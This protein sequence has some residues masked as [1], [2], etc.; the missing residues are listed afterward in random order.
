M[1]KKLFRKA[2]ALDKRIKF[3]FVG[4]LNTLVGVLVEIIVYLICGI[5]FSFSNKV[6]AGLSVIIIAS[7]VSQIVGTLHSYIWN[8]YFTFESKNKSISEFFK[9]IS[10]YALAFCISIGLKYLL[11]NVANIN[12]YIS[13]VIT[14]F[15]TTVISYVGH[16][17][18]SF[19]QR[20]KNSE[21]KDGIIDNN[22]CAENDGVKSDFNREDKTDKK[23]ENSVNSSADSFVNEIFITSSIDRDTKGEISV[24]SSPDKEIKVEHSVGS[25]FDRKEKGSTKQSASK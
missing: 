2:K 21:S 10:V 8:K 19:A 23:D 22:S 4:C 20:K 17:F 5:P 13:M 15:V 14:L 1:F 24:S 6:N 7:A 9:F 3:L 12:V 25:F 11:N 18:F 16:N